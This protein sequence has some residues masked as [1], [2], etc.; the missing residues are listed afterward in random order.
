[1]YNAGEVNIIVS[2]VLMSRYLLAGG[3]D[4]QEVR[5]VVVVN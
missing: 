5:V 2:C 3:E 1:M 4:N